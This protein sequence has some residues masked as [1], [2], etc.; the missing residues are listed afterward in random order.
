MLGWTAD[1]GPVALGVPGW[2]VRAYVLDGYLNPVPAGAPGEL[3]LAGVQLADGYLHRYGLT[4]Q[5]F[6]ANP[7]EAGARM[8]RTGDV[9]RWR[10][11]RRS[12]STSAAPTTR[13]SCA[14]FG[15]N[16][17]RSRPYSPR[18]PRC[19]R[20]G[21]SCAPTGWSPTTWRRRAPTPRPM[22]V[23]RARVGGVA[24]SHGAVGVRRG[25]RPSPDAERQA[26]PQRP[27]RAGAHRGDRSTPQRVTAQAARLCALFS[28]VLGAHVTSID[29]DFFALG[30]HSLLLVR[31]A[32][33]IRRELG[34]DVPVAS[35]MTG[36][37]RRR[38]RRRNWR[39]E[40]SAIGQPW[41]RCSRCA[42]REPSRRCSAC[43]PPVDSAG[44]SLD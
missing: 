30:G 16:R 37:D 38:G 10:R 9:V 6:V 3:Y 44:S 13:S 41:R 14:A 32:S 25:R 43:T 24:D 2:N 42:P 35:L 20:P 7:F 33:V 26:R 27:A 17:G 39:G 34:I 36:A 12:W 11:R 8:Y 22:V 31:L 18:T 28:E 19:R 21:W 15:S 29:D 5:T 1:G 4:A 23:A 40:R